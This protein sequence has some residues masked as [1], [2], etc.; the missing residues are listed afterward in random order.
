MFRLI[1]RIFLRLLLFWAL[2][3]MI[4]GVL[5]VLPAW[6]K[7][8]PPA[9]E[10]FAAALGVQFF[11]W[12]AIDAALAGFGLRNVARSE[13]TPHSFDQELRRRDKIIRILR[14]NARLNIG[15]VSLGAILLLFA[16]F[17][18]GARASL[19]GHGTGVVLQGGFLLIYDPLFARRL[20]AVRDVHE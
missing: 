4:V 14:F 3:S 20:S 9:G 11:I 10:V 12:G 15:W 2:A 7:P 5:A 1:E 13:A 8:D 16:W 19:L 17:Y 18:P 6:G